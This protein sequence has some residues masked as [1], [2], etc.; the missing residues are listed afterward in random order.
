M[1]CER[2]FSL[3]ALKSIFM[4]E[5][6]QYDVVYDPEGSARENRPNVEE[7]KRIQMGSAVQILQNKEKKTK[8]A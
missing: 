3:V 7:T 2:Q 5:N 4:S 1:W 8:E 6:V